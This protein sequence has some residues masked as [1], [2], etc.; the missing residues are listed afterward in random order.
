MGIRLRAGPG[1]LVEDSQDIVLAHDQMVFA[2]EL[3]LAARVL[4]EQDLVAG[5]Y[6]DRDKL[7]LVGVLALADGYHLALLRLF[8]GGVRDDDSTLGPLNFLDTLD[9][10]SIAQRSKSFHWGS[11]ASLPVRDWL[12]RRFQPF[13]K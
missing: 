10:N 11:V 6:F 5:L 12:A 8:L 3:Y 2:F 1:R 13:G 7:A 4:A 9:Q